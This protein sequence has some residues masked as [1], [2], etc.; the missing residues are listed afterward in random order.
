MKRK[1]RKQS[2][3]KNNVLVINDPHEPATLKGYRQHCKKVQIKYKCGIVV[4]T[5]DLADNQSINYHE[6]DPD[7]WSPKE[8]M[9][10]VDKKLKLWFRDFPKA[11]FTWG[12]HDKLPDRKR[13]T[14][15]LPKRCFKSFREMWK[16]PKGWVDGPEFV[17]HGVMFKHK[18]KGGINA[19]LNT[20]MACRQSVAIGHAHSIGSIAW[21]VNAR[22][23]IFGMCAGC[24]VDRKHPVMAYGK[25]MYNKPFIGC[26]VILN[27]GTLPLLIPMELNKKVKK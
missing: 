4:F 24:G 2:F 18:G 6:H 23:R 10:L 7:L 13:K 12:N 22:D 20:A 25:D 5:G 17:I 26:G 14:V 1:K 15:G 8:E 27:K 21:S 11:Y 9:D 3:S 19:A 16:L